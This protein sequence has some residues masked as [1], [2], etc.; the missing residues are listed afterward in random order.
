MVIFQSL[1]DLEQNEL[2][3]QPVLGQL[4]STSFINN[5]GKMVTVVMNES[6]EEMD[7]NLIVEGACASVSI[8]PRSIQTL[9]Y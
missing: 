2:V 8:S 1:S 9:I 7:Y 6:E 5:D 4:I 3:Q